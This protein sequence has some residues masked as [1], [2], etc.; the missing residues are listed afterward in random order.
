M[1]D[2]DGCSL[3][4]EDVV[5]AAI[6]C[7]RVQ[8]APSALLRMQASRRRVEA[9]VSGAAPVYALNTAVGLLAN[10]RLVETEIEAMQ[11]HLLRSHC[12]GV[13]APLSTSVVRGMMF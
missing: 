1:I 4:L 5:A 13:G 12:C 2:L 7:E 8:I 3:T 9:A 6:A 11:V 10:I